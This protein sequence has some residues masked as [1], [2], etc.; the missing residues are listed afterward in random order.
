MSSQQNSFVI[1]GYSNTVTGDSSGAV[2]GSSNSITGGAGGSFGSTNS[3][4]LAGNS[5][6]LGGTYGGNRFIQGHVSIPA[7]YAPVAFTAGASQAGMLVLG[8][9]TT[10]STPKVLT[11]AN[12]G[13]M[14]F[15]FNQL[16]LPSSQAAAYYFKGTVVA[17]INYGASKGW[18]FEGIMK[19]GLPSGFV[20]TPTITSGFSDAAASSWTVTLSFDSANRALA[21]SVVGASSDTVRWVCKLETTEVQF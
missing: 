18:T 10:N 13:G 21:V 3:S 8:A 15:D 6:I 20:G 14:T 11:S 12:Y 16:S 1:G 19:T 4:T 17:Y 7:S 5:I 2:G 9:V